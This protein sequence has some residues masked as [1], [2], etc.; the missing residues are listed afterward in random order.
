MIQRIL[1]NVKSALKA[2]F[3]LLFPAFCFSCKELLKTGE[4]TICRECYQ[5]QTQVSETDI[6]TF[7]R[8][9]PAQH[10][11]DLLILFDYTD[12]LQDVMHYFKY[13]G[14]FKIADYF[15]DSFYR[16]LIKNDYDLITCVPLHKTK[17]RERGY[18]Q[19]G[20]IALKLAELTGIEFAAHALL[21]QV[22]TN[23]QTKLSRSERIK[24]VAEAF[25]ADKIVFEKKILLVDDVITTGATVNACASALK[26]SGAITVDIIALATPLD[27]LAKN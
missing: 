14:Y 23:S 24:N 5:N 1:L 16:K 11:D 10:F 21:R 22:Y 18:N 15:A 12:L 13:E 9:L 7:I 3:D 6:N 25:T 27:I 19:S 2:S 4:T 17:Q 8:R 26:K 20:L